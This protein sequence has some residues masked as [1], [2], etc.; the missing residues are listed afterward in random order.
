MQGIIVIRRPDHKYKKIG[1]RFGSQAS[2]DVYFGDNLLDHIPY[3]GLRA[4]YLD[5]GYC[6]FYVKMDWCR[7]NIVEID[8]KKGDFAL[9]DIV[10]PPSGSSS[11]IRMFTRYENYFILRRMTDPASI[12]EATLDI[13]ARGL[14][15]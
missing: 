6:S 14:P 11:L 2:F 15:L 12:Q 7:S 8:L 13:V 4:Y 3:N 5:E 9:Y 10:Y 1:Q